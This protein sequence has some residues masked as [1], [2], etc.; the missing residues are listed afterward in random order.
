MR[1]FKY[2]YSHFHI[3]FN[4]NIA[5]Q[6]QVV[7]DVVSELGFDAVDSGSLSD[8]WRQQPGT[9]AYC[10]ELTKDELRKALKEAKKEKA[11]LLRDKVMGIFA[12]KKGVEFSHEDVVNLNREIYNS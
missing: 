6:K 4:T 1:E 7:M 9:P 12:E 11:P 8:S 3:D 5:S 10:T 2:I